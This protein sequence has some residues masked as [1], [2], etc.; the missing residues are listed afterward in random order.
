MMVTQAYKKRPAAMASTPA[1]TLFLSGRRILAV[2][3]AVAMAL[4]RKTLLTVLRRRLAR[5]GGAVDCADPA[6]QS[7]PQ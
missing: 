2:V 6:S 1:F 4:S 5:P 7:A 3:A